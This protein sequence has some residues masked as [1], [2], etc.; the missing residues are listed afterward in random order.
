AFATYHRGR[1]SQTERWLASLGVQSSAGFA[2]T[3]QG[4]DERSH[5][6]MTRFLDARSPTTLAQVQQLIVDYRDFYNTLR[7]Q[8]LLR[9]KMHITPAQAWE[10]ISHAQP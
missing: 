7:H 8:G 1:L 10:I 2:P 5:Q 9:G 6:T 4:K 3:T